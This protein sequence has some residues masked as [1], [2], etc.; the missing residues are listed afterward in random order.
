MIS[1]WAG[2]KN[3]HPATRRHWENHGKSNL[4]T[5]DHMWNTDNISRWER[6]ALGPIP[7]VQPWHLHSQ[8]Q[9]TA[10][11][12]NNLCLCCTFQKV[13]LPSI[14]T[15]ETLDVELRKNVTEQRGPQNTARHA[16]IN[17]NPKKRGGRSQMRRLR[18]IGCER[19]AG[20]ERQLN[21]KYLHTRSSKLTCCG[22]N[23]S[24][25]PSIEPHRA[26][27]VGLM[28]TC[29]VMLNRHTSSDR[30]KKVCTS[31]QHLCRVL[32]KLGFCFDVCYLPLITA[33]M[34][35]NKWK[36]SP[37]ASIFKIYINVRFL[38]ASRSTFHPFNSKSNQSYW[39]VR[40]LVLFFLLINDINLSP[41]MEY[42]LVYCA[43]Q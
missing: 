10:E 21:R 34:L 41:S 30:G 5:M 15:L 7:A 43:Q 17:D 25:L 20:G 27:H 3:M 37:Y 40:G 29:R 24:H 12:N 32:F 19:A 36:N 33:K 6:P 16:N 22:E 11:N 18:L 38:F 14:R 2:K 39:R 23:R 1:G 26:V 9:N 31:N 28:C 13:L 8:W 42:F 4:I 35:Q